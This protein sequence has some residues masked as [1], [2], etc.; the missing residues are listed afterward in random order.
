[1][2]PSSA[3]VL[4]YH[5]PNQAF[6]HAL[7]PAFGQ[8]GRRNGIACRSG[9]PRGTQMENGRATRRAYGREMRGHSSVTASACFSANPIVCASPSALIDSN[10]SRIQCCSKHQSIRR[11]AAAFPGTSLLGLYRVS[12]SAAARD[13]AFVGGDAAR[14]LKQIATDN[15]P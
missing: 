2:K 5:M 14:P 13:D 11:S 6:C 9:V 10:C 3:S 15:R 4:L 7:A 1:M 12:Y 8:P